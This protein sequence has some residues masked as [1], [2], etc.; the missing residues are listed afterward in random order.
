M[1]QPFFGAKDDAAE[2]LVWDPIAASTWRKDRVSKVAQRNALQWECQLLADT[3]EE[4]MLEYS[5]EHH[6]F[7]SV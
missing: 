6:H 3:M 2:I 5:P 1:L 7:A 4:I